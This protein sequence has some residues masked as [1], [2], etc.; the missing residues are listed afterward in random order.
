MSTQAPAATP[1]QV[2][3]EAISAIGH[4]V[5]DIADYDDKS[6]TLVHHSRRLSAV[7]ENLAS[8]HEALAPTPQDNGPPLPVLIKFRGSH[9]IQS[10][11]SIP[12]SRRSLGNHLT[13]F[14]SPDRLAQITGQD[15]I[16]P[17]L[18]AVFPTTEGP[19][20]YTIHQL[21][22]DLEQIA[23]AI[24]QQH[25]R[26]IR[27]AP[28]VRLDDLQAARAMIFVLDCLDHRGQHDPQLMQRVLDKSDPA[29]IRM[30][31]NSYAHHHP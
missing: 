30:L 14:V 10:D 9:P 4:A 25:D 12:Q 16:R 3:D 11:P 2:L 28:S 13:G 5:A 21:D 1:A 24:T 6:E 26:T 7:Q 31:F 27:A 8:L 23:E 20:S 19:R 18:G 17:W 15:S 29:L 22:R